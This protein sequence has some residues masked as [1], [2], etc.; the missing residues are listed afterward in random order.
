[1]NLSTE[2]K[3]WY[4]L[5]IQKNCSSKGEQSKKLPKLEQKEASSTESAQHSDVPRKSIS[6]SIS[7]KIHKE[8]LKLESRN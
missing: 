3:L 1:M 6:A 7:I 5:N 2:E 8:T 4:K